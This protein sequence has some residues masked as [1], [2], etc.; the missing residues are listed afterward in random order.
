MPRHRLMFWMLSWV[1]L[2]FLLFH[3]MISPA[4]HLLVSLLPIDQQSCP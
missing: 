1:S 2:N 3:L 4:S